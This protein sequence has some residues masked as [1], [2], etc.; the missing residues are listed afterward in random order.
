MSSGYWAILAPGGFV[1]ETERELA[2]KNLKAIKKSGDFFL[3]GGEPQEIAWSSVR[4]LDVKAIPV[5]S[6]NDAARKLKPLAKKWLHFERAHRGRGNLILGELRAQK[7]EPVKFPRKLM[8][9]EGCGAF[10]FLDDDKTVY[11]CRDFDRPHPLGL[12]T[13]L[14]DKGNPPSRAYLKLWEAFCVFGGW[15]G[16][17]EATM[18]LGS[19][20]GGWTWVLATLGAQVLSVD[21]APLEPGIEA[22]SGVTFKKGDAFQ[23][24][25]E[26]SAPVEW[27]CSDVICA[28]EKLLELVKVWVESGQA[29]HFA[30]TLKFQGEAD[31]QVVEEFRKYG[32]VLHLHHNKHELTFLK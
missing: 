24:L 13:F 25:P 4:W 6:I 21:R 16:P 22:M 31:P 29:A 17:G 12:V 20:P 1:E 14:E 7:F 10:T 2:H 3:F 19:C 27:L 30:C 9:P 32:R 28:P 23:V 26:N 15:P 5:A 18:D 11:Y 8:L